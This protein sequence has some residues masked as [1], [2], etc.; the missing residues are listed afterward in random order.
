M[1]ICLIKGPYTADYGPVP[2]F[3]VEG[4][5]NHHDGDR[6]SEPGFSIRLSMMPQYLFKIVHRYN[7]VILYSLKL[8]CLEMCVKDMARNKQTT[9]VHCNKKPG[10]FW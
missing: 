3:D 4:H 9:T 7:L 10:W 1:A 6:N 2:M 8:V 5:I